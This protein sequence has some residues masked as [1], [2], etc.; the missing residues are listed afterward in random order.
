[1]AV[2]H[3]TL[4]RLV[5]GKLSYADKCYEAAGGEPTLALLLAVEGRWM[6]MNER[7]RFAARRWALLRLLALGVVQRPY[8]RAPI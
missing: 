8:R 7:E 1:M 4:G 6:Q 3:D 5:Q 2:R